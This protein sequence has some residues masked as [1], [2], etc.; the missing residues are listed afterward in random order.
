[1]RARGSEKHRDSRS[2]FP[3]WESGQRF[4]CPYGTQP[5]DAPSPASELAGYYQLSLQD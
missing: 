5:G 1:M 3:S 2:R 4:K